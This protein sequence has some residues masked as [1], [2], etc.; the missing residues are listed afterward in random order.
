MPTKYTPREV[1]YA[2]RPIENWTGPPRCLSRSCQY[3]KKWSQVVHDLKAELGRIGV[4]T[5]VLQLDISERDLRN[6]GEL[7]ANARPVSDRVC[8]SFQHP[9]QG[10]LAYPCHTFHD[11][12]ANVQAIA[13]T[14]EALPEAGRAIVT[15]GTVAAAAPGATLETYSEYL[16]KMA[17]PGGYAE[18]EIA[19]MIDDPDMLRDVYRTASKNHHPDNGGDIATMALI[20]KARD[21]IRAHQGAQ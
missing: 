4:R 9:E 13:M 2:T 7:R 21:A 6:D 5:A 15:P 16:L 14:L 12:Q 10:P 19:V 17:F 18:E 1:S 20:N 11:W 3:Q 8:V